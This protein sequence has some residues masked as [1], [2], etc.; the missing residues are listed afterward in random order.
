MG[1]PSN[2][3]SSDLIR[4]TG[5]RVT[6]QRIAVLEAVGEKPHTSAAMVLARVASVVPGTSHQA[7]YDCLAQLTEA[8][9]LRRISVD[10]GAALYETRTHDNH[11]HFVCRNCGLVAD[12]DCA[13]GSAP[14][15]GVHGSDRFV[16][17]EAEITYRGLC[18]ACAEARPSP[19]L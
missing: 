1:L 3:P 2:L 17:D 12:V 18:P 15:L 8:G 7:V 14:C 16:I 13:V 6:R 9:L 4:A 5:M 10:G 11:H 19:A